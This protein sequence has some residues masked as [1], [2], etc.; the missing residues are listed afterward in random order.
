MENLFLVEQ[1]KLDLSQN[2]LVMT[3]MSK[4]NIRHNIERYFSNGILN[5]LYGPYLY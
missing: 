1:A 2:V 3:R 4:R 5:I